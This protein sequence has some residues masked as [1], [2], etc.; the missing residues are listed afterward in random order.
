[1]MLHNGFEVADDGLVLPQLEKALAPTRRR[2][3]VVV[4]QPTAGAGAPLGLDARQ[5]RAAPLLDRAAPQLRRRRHVATGLHRPRLARQVA[6]APR[7]HQFRLDVQLVLRGAH[8]PQPDLVVR[9]KQLPQPGDVAVDDVA[10]LGGMRAVPDAVR[11]C[12]DAHRGA[13]GQRQTGQHARLFRR[14]APL[15]A[16]LTGDLDRTEQPDQHRPEFAGE[17]DVTVHGDFR[18]GFECAGRPEGEAH[19]GT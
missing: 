5:R 2:R 6:H 10:G 13:G 12:L 18:C 14:P 9:F 4:A 3:E 16:V 8:A 19:P 15:P 11:Q 1:M 17:C 7:V